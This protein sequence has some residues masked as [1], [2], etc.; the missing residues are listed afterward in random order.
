MITPIN[1]PIN[2]KINSTKKLRLLFVMMI[3]LLA[4]Q[5]AAVVSLAISPNSALIVTPGVDVVRHSV[6]NI[7]LSSD[8]PYDIQLS[9]DTNGQLMNGS[10]G[11]AYQVSYDNNPEISLSRTPIVV[12][13]GLST[14]TQNKVIGVSLK[15]TDT[16]TAIAGDYTSTLMVTITGY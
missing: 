1:K 10:Y 3:V 12:E 8:Q 5:A 11:I 14:V 15:G 9:D 7:T 2:T 6:A 13:S 4:D 16:A